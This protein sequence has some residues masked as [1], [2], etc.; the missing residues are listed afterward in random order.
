MGQIRTI[1]L[2]GAGR[3]AV[4][5]AR[6]IVQLEGWRL[7]EV[8]ARR[9]EALDSMLAAL[10]TCPDRAGKAVCTAGGQTDIL[11][12]QSTSREGSIRTTTELSD[13]TPQA[14]YYLFA[15]SDAALP[16]VWAEMPKTQGVW[17]HTAGSVELQAMAQYHEASGVLYP[18]QTFSHER[19]LDWSRLPLYIEGANEN[20]HLAAKELALALS[21]LVYEANSQQRKA[22]H[23]GAVLACNFSNHLIALAQAWL[24]RNDLPS[25]SLLPLVR[26]TISKLDTIPAHKAQTGPAQRGDR[27]TLE[28]HTALLGDLPQLRQLYTLLSESIIQTSGQSTLPYLT[29]K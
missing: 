12:N 14:D 23:L 22:L 2:L 21:P 16:D 27:A 8:Y 24:V 7:V 3:V 13:L 18:L 17:L 15:L 6:R 10:D 26:E 5:L 11:L 28:Q 20:A 29:L 25:E 19:E 9:P 1:A 4:H